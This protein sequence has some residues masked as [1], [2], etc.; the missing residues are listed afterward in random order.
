MAVYFIGP[1]IRNQVIEITDK[2]FLLYS[3]GRKI[4]LNSTNLY[5]I[6]EREK[7]IKSYRFR[8]NRFE[9]YQV[10]SHAYH[11]GIRLQEQFDQLFKVENLKVNVVNEK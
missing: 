6:V 5:E 2:G 9:E 3:F 10:T 7:G 8:K 4:E 1:V 11:D